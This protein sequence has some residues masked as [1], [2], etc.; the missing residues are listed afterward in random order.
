MAPAL[1]ATPTETVTVPP[2]VRRFIPAGTLP[3]EIETADLD[4]DGRPDVV[5]VVERQKAKPDD[6]DIEDD[7]R[8]ILVLLRQAD[9]SLELAARNDKAAYCST[10][11]G[12]FGDPFAGVQVAPRSF[13][14]SNY[15]GSAWRWSAEYRFA[16]SRRDA[17]WQ[18]VRVTESSFHASNPDKAKTKVSTPPK[19]Y[20]RIDFAD[21]DPQ[22]W[23]GQG[24]R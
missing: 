11:G 2:E 23:K 21:F 13:T 3:I 10:C 19:D 6:E 24:P 16:W 17:T 22:H 8:P 9:G 7:Q 5:L 15:G 14:V 4:G 20:G 12:V 18:L 1:A